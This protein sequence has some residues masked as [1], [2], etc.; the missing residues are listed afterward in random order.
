[1]YCH[2]LEKIQFYC[3]KLEC[4]EK[5]LETDS[6]DGYTILWRVRVRVINTTELYI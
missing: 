4:V 3:I 5:V 2:C 6:S 1:M